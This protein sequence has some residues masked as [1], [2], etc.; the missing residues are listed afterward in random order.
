[1]G[2]FLWDDFARQC[3]WMVRAGA[4]GFVWPVMASEFTVLSY[5]ER[6]QGMQVAVDTVAGRIPVVAGVADTSKDGAVALAEEAAQAGADAIIAMPP[7]ATHLDHRELFEDYYRALAHAAGGLPVII[8]NCGAPLGS[9]LPGSFVVK[10]C[11]MIPEVQY[12]KEEKPPQGH[13]VSEVIALAGPEVKGVFSGA[14]C[15]WIFTEYK[16]GVCGNMPASTL[17]DIDA[18]I[19]NLLEAGREDEARDIH[20]VRLVLENALQSMPRRKG[21]KEIMVRRGVFGHAAGRNSREHLDDV[22][23]AEID[24]AY[25]LLEPYFSA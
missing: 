1:M 23:L 13:A 14:G 10:L 18:Q 4:H 25:G 21:R 6:V 11:A 16:R 9:S 22:D 20:N 5:R 8:Q 24:Y 19:W 3:D 12:L 15:R 7:W 17:T 2:A